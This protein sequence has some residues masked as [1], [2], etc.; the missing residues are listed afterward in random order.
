M[1]AIVATEGLGLFN[2]SKQPLRTTGLVFA[3]LGVKI[4][5]CRAILVVFP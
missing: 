4:I 1:T 3:E 2:S 5:F